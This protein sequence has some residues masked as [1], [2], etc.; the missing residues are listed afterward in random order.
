M[1]FALWNL[2]NLSEHPES[3]PERDDV[4]SAE[5]ADLFASQ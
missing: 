5:K 2:L 1:P 4:S 3:L